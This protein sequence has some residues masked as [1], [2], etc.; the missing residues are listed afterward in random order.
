MYNSRAV[1]YIHYM[2]RKRTQEENDRY[3]KELHQLYVVEN[4]TMYE[5]AERLGIAAPTVH[6]ILKQ[7]NFPSLRHLKKGFNNTTRK[8]IIPNSYSIDLAEFFGIMLGDGHISP[9]QII[10]TLGTK[11]LEYVSHVSEI[12]EKVFATKPSIFT[13]PAPNR[14][15]KYRNVYFGSVVLV[16]WLLKEGL[17]HD[18]AK[19]Q[20]DIPRW[21][22]LN[23][24]YMKAFVRG[25]FDT[26]GSIY[27][28]R[29]GIQISF[30]NHSTPL[31]ESLHSVLIKLGYSPSRVSVRRIYIT[32]VKDVKRFFE[33][34]SPQ[35]SKHQRLFIDF[36]KRVGTQA[37]NE[38]RL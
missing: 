4:L 13:R 15:D 27:K 35:N 18:K 37:V 20:V 17:V 33:E 12:M 5:V 28:L 3:R 23:E 25:F 9:T 21:I 26:D 11:E 36:I 34:I 22:F 30:T 29:F 2:A 38:I 31:L 7:L 32:R 19:E 6:K 1:N 24:N 14:N 16:R 10:V 8:V